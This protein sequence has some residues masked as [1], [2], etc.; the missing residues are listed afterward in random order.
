MVHV[1]LQPVVLEAVRERVHR[2]NPRAILNDD[3]GHLPVQLRA[4][5][6]VLHLADLL[7]ELV[8]R[9]VAVVRVVRAGRAV[10]RVEQ[11]EKILR[12][13]IIRHPAEAEQLR[14]P[15][16][17]FLEEGRPVVVAQLDDDPDLF[18][19]VRE[20]LGRL[21]ELRILRGSQLQGELEPAAGRGVL[22]VRITGLGQQFFRA[23][24]VEREWRRLVRVARYAGRNR[25]LRTDDAVVVEPDVLV[26]VEGAGH[27]LPELFVFADNRVVHVEADVEQVEGRRREQADAARG[28]LAGEHLVLRDHRV[29]VVARDAGRF[30]L[31]G[32]EHQPL[33]RG[34]LDH[35]LDDAVDERDGLAGVREQLRIRAG[36]GAVGVALDAAGLR[37]FRIPHELVAVVLAIGFEDVRPGADGMIHELLAVELDR[38][39]RN[40]KAVV[41]REDPQQLRV[42]PRQLDL[43]GVAV[44]GAKALD[45]RGVVGRRFAAGRFAP[46]IQA[47]DAVVERPVARRAVLQVGDALHGVDEILGDE[48][49]ALAA[50]FL[51]AGIVL[52]VD[53]LANSE[54]VSQ[55][56]AR[57]R[58]HGFGEQRFHPV[59]AVEIG[60][61]KQPF[62]D[63]AGGERG[64]NVAGP[65]R[66]EAANLGRLAEVHHLAGGALPL[67]LAAAAAG[68]EQDRETEKTSCDGQEV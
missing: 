42:R 68:T 3:V 46:R 41:H 21:P 56:V 5:G 1:V 4:P 64:R 38:L 40:G 29:P 30:E 50:G 17:H 31:A 11:L 54:G 62:E 24:K 26:R 2:E 27:R 7:V 58:G 20:Q 43:Q 15:P 47:D 45:F 57:H 16:L 9:G 12:V 22:A 53:A 14:L 35:V 59:R 44:Q 25:A 28:E 32:Q 66:V 10:R 39:A 18:H 61:L 8:E 63:L 48:F 23:I 52:E 37:P 19:E 49:A 60:I 36:R 6:R 55:A 51:E 13:G 33:G 34:V 65:D 67:E